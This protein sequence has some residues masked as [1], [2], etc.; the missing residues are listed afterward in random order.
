MTRN[1]KWMAAIGLMLLAASCS[2]QPVTG[3]TPGVLTASGKPIGDIQVTFYRLDGGIW[4]SV[5][6]GTSAAD[7]TFELVTNGAR[8]PLHLEPGQYRCTL[9]SVGAPVEIPRECMETADTPLEVNWSETDQLIQL[10]APITV[11]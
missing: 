10:D 3:G 2:R 8:G 11:R 1:R 5:G 9:E 4:E 7:G 6:F